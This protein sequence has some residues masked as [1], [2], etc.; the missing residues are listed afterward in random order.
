MRRVRAASEQ[1][2]AE[3]GHAPRL[4]AVA[5]RCDLSVE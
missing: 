2:S 5:D 4:A 3:L 1:L